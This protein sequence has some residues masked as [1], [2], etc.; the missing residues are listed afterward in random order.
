MSRKVDIHHRSVDN[1]LVR[2]SKARID[3]FERIKTR[4]TADERTA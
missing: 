3:R 4:E 2:K 1:L